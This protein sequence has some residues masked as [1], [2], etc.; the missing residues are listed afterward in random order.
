MEAQLLDP[1]NNLA[2]FGIGKLAGNRWR[3]Y[4]IHLI[5]PVLLAFLDDINYIQDKRFIRNGTKRT[6]INTS[7]AGYA[8]FI[9]NGRGLILVHRDGLYL[10]GTNTGSFKILDRAVGADLCALPAFYAFAFIDMRLLLMIKG[11]GSSFADILASMRKAAP[12][13]LGYF[14]AAHRALIAGN[15]DHFDDIRVVFISAH[16]NFNPL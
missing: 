13:G 12:A 4:R 16:R 11:N 1:R 3:N 9:I 8:F 10:A 5:F 14:I 7:A 6:L 15:I 2:E